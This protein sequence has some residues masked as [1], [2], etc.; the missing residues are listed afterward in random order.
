[1]TADEPRLRVT[2]NAAFGV[3]LILLGTTLMLDRLQILDAQQ[4]LSRFWPIALVL[5]G[6]ALVIQSFQRPG[7]SPAGREQMRLGPIIVW[8]IVAVF[9]WNGFSRFEP[10]SARTDSS[11]TSS[12]AAVMSRHRQ[13]SNAAVFRAAEVTAVMG[14]AELDLRKTAPPPD[15]EATI[16]VFGLMG[17]VTIYVP[18]GWQVDIRA[19]PVMGGTR[20]RRRKPQDAAPGS[21]RIVIRGLIMLGGL[22]IRS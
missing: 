1:M 3:C 13:V 20:D 7:E 21:P 15:A 14:R 11:E 17:G 22:D 4:V 9:L 19:T 6:A 8:T 18:E 10:S 2:T 12:V 16:E 5:F